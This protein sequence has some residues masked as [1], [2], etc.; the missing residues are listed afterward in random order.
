M[1]PRAS[2]LRTAAVA[3]WGL[4]AAAFLAAAP[5]PGRACVGRTL[6]VGYYDAPEQVMVAQILSVF[7][8]ERTGTTVKMT[9]F[10]TRDE[11]F[12]AIRNDKVSLYADYSGIVLARFGGEAPGPDPERNFARLK[13]LLNRKH[14]V[15]WLEPF[16]FDGNVSAGAPR[17]AAAEG[18]AGLMLCKDAL[19]KFPAL[20]KLLGKLRGVLDNGTMAGLLREAKESDPRAVARRFLKS[21]KLI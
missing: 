6:Y 15:I 21:R 2:A 14:N 10:A 3:L 8:D 12:E 1:K 11:A 16:G 20:P 9:R 19:S 7:I 13:E 17:P 18:T 4:A 5:V